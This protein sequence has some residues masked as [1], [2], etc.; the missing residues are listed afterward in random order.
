MNRYMFAAVAAMVIGAGAMAEKVT[1][2]KSGVAVAEYE[3][4]ENDSVVFSAGSAEK[5]AAD[6]V[7][8]K[9]DCWR[10]VTLPAMP[11]M[12]VLVADDVN[13]EVVA[14]GADSVNITLPACHYT[15]GASEFDL[16]SVI[17]KCGVEKN[18]DA[19]SISGKFE[20]NVGDKATEVTVAGKLDADGVLSLSQDMK[21]G[22]MPMALHMEYGNNFTE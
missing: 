22:S 5:S 15:M 17:V 4:A 12:G 2:Y 14:D 6:A 19:Y 11:N 9:Y 7:A 3:L 18:G 21:Y 20:G 1:V 10:K 8:G 13:L 16:P